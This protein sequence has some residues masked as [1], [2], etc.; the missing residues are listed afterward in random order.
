MRDPGHRAEDWHP[1]R[2]VVLAWSIMGVALSLAGIILFAATYAFARGEGGGTIEISLMALVVPTLVVFV[3]LG[4][5]E[6]IHGLTMACLGARPQYGA[7]LYKHV[8]PYFYCTSPGHGF[9]RAQFA[10]VSA[11]PLVLV[12]SAGALSVAFVPLGGW[13]VVP[14]GVHLGGC[15]G[16]IWFLGIIARLPQGTVLENLATG[17]RIMRPVV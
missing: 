6:W 5:H 3:L 11:A 15:I 13:L 2:E 10:A 7:G 8:M 17:V 4:A 1:S 9:T 12:S 16:D 14:L